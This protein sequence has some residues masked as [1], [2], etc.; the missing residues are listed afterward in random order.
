MMRP[1]YISQLSTANACEE[2]I[3]LFY[4][5]FGQVVN[6]TVAGAREVGSMFNIYFAVENLLSG[7]ALREYYAGYGSLVNK[8]EALRALIEARFR[9]EC[10]PARM[11]HIAARSRLPV[12][13][14]NRD[15]YPLMAEYNAECA[16]A[17]AKYNKEYMP[18]WAA[19]MADRA[20][21]W[22]TCYITDEGVT[23]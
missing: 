5:T 21:L 6:V 16:D 15:T 13:A 3:I 17:Q 18:I 20:A 10:E 1:L 4:E 7:S 19:F 12:T 8:R 9:V 14:S 23:A 11:K 2:Q 22:A